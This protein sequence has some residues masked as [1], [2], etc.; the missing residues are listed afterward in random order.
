MGGRTDHLIDAGEKLGLK[1]EDSVALV[2]QQQAIERK[3]RKIKREER[4]REREELQ[5]QEEARRASAEEDKHREEARRRH[6]IEMKQLEL[7]VSIHA[8]II[9]EGGAQ[10]PNPKA[11]KLPVFA[12]GT[13]ELDNY[14]RQFERF[15]TNSGWKETEWA[16]YLSALL[17]GKVLD[18]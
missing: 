6:E 4:R 17:T 14:L 11:L 15:A 13:N 3:E 2:S 16:S 8:V 1:S 7:E 9:G 10:G 18:V 5:R 12:D